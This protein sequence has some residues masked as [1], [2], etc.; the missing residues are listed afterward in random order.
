MGI[1]I[2]FRD[3]GR[4]YKK[5]V[6]KISLVSF[7][8]IFSL[9][10]FTSATL[11]LTVDDIAK[12]F[13]SVF[14]PS[15]T[16]ATTGQVSFFQ[17]VQ[18]LFSPLAAVDCGDCLTNP[19]CVSSYGS[20]YTC[21]KYHCCVQTSVGS[22]PPPPSCTS[23]TGCSG[24]QCGPDSCGNPN[25]CGTCDQF[26]GYVCQ[27]G[28]CIP[29]VTSC[30][31]NGG[32]CR[33]GYCYGGET[34]LSGGCV[35]PLICC[36]PGGGCTNE[37]TSGQQ[38][39]TS[40]IS[41]KVCRLGTDGCSHWNTFSCPSTQTCDQTTGTCKTGTMSQ[42]TDTGG[43]CRDSSGQTVSN[44]CSGGI[45]TQY[46][47]TS[48]DANGQ[49]VSSTKYCSDVCG[50]SQWS[51]SSNACVCNSAPICTS[52]NEAANCA[53]YTS[54]DRCT[55][56]KCINNACQ[57]Q[58]ATDGTSCTTSSA[59]SGTCKSGTCVATPKCPNGYY[60][61]SWCY[62]KCSSS[63]QCV[64]SQ[65]YNGCYLCTALTS[66]PT[67]GALGGYDSGSFRSCRQVAYCNQGET[68]LGQSSD[69]Q[70]CCVPHSRV[71]DGTPCTSDSSC[72]TG[73]WCKCP[74]GTPAYCGVSAGYTCSG[75]YKCYSSGPAGISCTGSGAAC[76]AGQQ[77]NCP[78]GPSDC[79]TDFPNC[80][81]GKCCKPDG[82]GASD[83]F[84]SS[85]SAWCCSGQATNG[86]CG[87]SSNPP[88]PS[89]SPSSCPDSTSYSLPQGSPGDVACGTDPL[90]TSRMYTCTNGRWNSGS[91]CSYGCS[92]D[93]KSCASSP[94]PSP[95]QTCSDGTALWGCSATKPAMCTP[96]GFRDDCGTCGCPSDKYCTITG[97]CSP[98]LAN[99]ENCLA[100]TSTITK[101]NGDFLDT[102]GK[103][104][105][106][107]G[108]ASDNC[109]K[110]ANGQ[111]NCGYVRHVSPTYC[112]YGCDASATPNQCK[113]QPPT[114]PTSPTLPPCWSLPNGVCRT[115]CL[116]GEEP[117]QGSCSYPQ[118]GIGGGN[119]CCKLNPTPP[120]QPP[121]VKCIVGSDVA[122]I[123]E[124]LPGKQPKWCIMG[125]YG[126]QFID[127][128]N[129]CPCPD[130]W[131]CD[132]FTGHC[133]P[134]I[135]NQQ[136]SQSSYEYSVPSQESLTVIL[137]VGNTLSQPLVVSS[138]AYTDYNVVSQGFVKTITFIF[139]PEFKVVT[140][141]YFVSPS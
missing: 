35:Y 129:A 116:N 137:P 96:A 75:G 42:C 59:A 125:D 13:Q 127:N 51:C 22:S 14:Q 88:A 83:W 133:N 5:G 117:L 138:D 110:G 54:A 31:A 12:S 25:G 66:L 58:P 63:Q 121:D 74:T 21:N 68:N 43:F 98:R 119:V 126:P 102:L 6:N 69:C 41:Y 141:T 70:A 39:C 32:N 82:Y 77:C 89:P 86:K 52:A 57:G 90:G 109:K 113:P 118:R 8:L 100:D 84:G 60:D 124:C 134:Q 17:W 56:G 27:G 99:T 61:A 87:V 53:S 20:G 44:S 85:H 139:Y 38:Q 26:P 132:Y 49:C 93:R 47:C 55:V 92:A 76:P 107:F 120:G 11:A 114:P 72:G 106:T 9:A 23:G 115:A 80:Q 97:E 136:I 65:V 62:N 29:Q 91:T 112:Q 18:S 108:E 40:S 67:C 111:T 128:C 1:S 103:G 73:S 16:A 140:N 10:V 15:H 135:G 50:S 71:P 46:T 24:K 95:P 81:N 45:L 3:S 101:C 131:A 64:V 34:Q 36:M 79:N 4:S 28:Q 7:I 122:R 48:H 30:N 78:N 104:C 123:G 19:D 2:R 94:S 105:N 33:Q 130:H 37:C